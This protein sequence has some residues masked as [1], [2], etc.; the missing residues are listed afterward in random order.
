[1]STA[2]VFPGQGSQFPGMGRAFYEGWETTRKR[3]DTLDAAIDT[4]LHDLCFGEGSEALRRTANT[5]PAVFAVGAA[6]HAGVCERICPPD[7]VAGHSLGHITAAAAA[8]ALSDDAG[9]ELVRR[10]GELMQAAARANGP[11]TM[12]SVLLADPE[13]VAEVCDQYAAASVAGFNG[14]RHTVV[15]GRSEAVADVRADLDDRTRA[16]FVDLDVSAAFHSPVME[17]AA[18]PFAD[19][20]EATPFRPATI[21]ICS[22][23][24]GEIYTDPEVARRDL[25][26]QLTAPIDWVGVVERLAELGVTRYVAFPPAGTLSELIDR[27]TPDAKIV[28]LEGPADI[29]EVTP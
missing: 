7:Y 3:F 25:A 26:T 2:Y 17:P 12:V 24:T 21:P 10:R 27:I 18:G 20:L 13:T 22:D 29:E 28:R 1:M 19:T 16:R 14:P 11:G 4:D 15:S 6:T 5:Q 9:I 23:V 8:G